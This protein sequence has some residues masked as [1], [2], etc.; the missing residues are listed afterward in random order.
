MKCLYMFSTVLNFLYFCFF[1]GVC[2]LPSK[3][4]IY[5]QFGVFLILVMT[6]SWLFATFFFLPLCATF[7]DILWKKLSKRNYRIRKL[8]TKEHQSRGQ[9]SA[10]KKEKT[11]VKNDR[12]PRETQKR[13]TYNTWIQSL[14]GEDHW[15][16]TK[17]YNLRMKF[18]DIEQTFKRLKYN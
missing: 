15:P 12:K 11:S 6:S 16:M 3:V 2:M 4:L 10:C 14:Y 13:M 8:E 1:S 18:L 17:P 5:R 7:G 9:F